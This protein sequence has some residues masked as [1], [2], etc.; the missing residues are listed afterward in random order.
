MTVTQAHRRGRMRRRRLGVPP[1]TVET[2]CPL[3][4][5]DACTLEVT[6]QRRPD[7]QHR[8]RRTANPVTGGYICAKVRRFDQRV[9]GDDRLLYPAVRAARRATA[10]FKRV[11][12]TTRW[13]LIA[14][15]LRARRDQRAAAR[16]IL[17]LCYGG[18]NGLLTQDYADAHALPAARRRRGCRARCAPRPPAPPTWRSTARWRRSAT[19]TIPRRELILLWGVNPRRPAST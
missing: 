1:T 2:A 18:S 7:H 9:Y 5:P 19:R 15:K 12:G 6:V 17:P 10:Q 3:D 11:T 13:T 16:P 8:R 14:E 4:C